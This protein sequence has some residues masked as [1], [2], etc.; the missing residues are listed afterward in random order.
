MMPTIQ[1]AVLC[2]ICLFAGEAIAQRDFSQVQIEPI[3]VQGNIY[4][5]KG[6]GGNIGASVGTDGVLI[7]DDQFAPLS[8]KIRAALKGL[9]GGDPTFVL[10]THWHG[11]H[12]GGNKEFGLKAPIIAH[13]NVRNRLIEG[14]ASGRRPIPPAPKEALPVITF[15][16]SLSIH[17]NGEEIKAIHVPH[18]HTDGDAVIFFTKSNVVHMGDLFFAGGFP[19]VDLDSGGSVAGYTAGVQQVIQQMP[20]NVQVIP[21]HG[22]PSTLDGLKEFHRMLTETVGILRKQMDE[23][24]SLDD[25]KRAGLLDAWQKWGS[26]FISTD[27]WIETIYNSYSR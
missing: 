12:T 21:G 20:S 16:A 22:E 1:A 6:Q 25:I 9:G 11:D 3:S 19:F 2:T 15:D 7:V 13:T 24:K 26:G 23:G 8:E 27:R 5:L 14:R 17:F 4:M 18:G 10:N